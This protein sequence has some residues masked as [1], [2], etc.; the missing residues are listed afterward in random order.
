MPMK[1]L[2]CAAVIALLA[3]G[4]GGAGG[5]RRMMISTSM[6]A[7]SDFVVEEP[8]KCATGVEALNCAAPFKLPPNGHVTDFSTREW[9]SSS[10]K[11]CNE[12]GMHGSIFS[13]KGNGANDSNAISVNTMDASLRLAL[14]VSSGSYGG[15]GIAF[16]AGCLDA[17]AFSGLQFSIAVA[18]GSLSGCAY[19]IQLQTFEQR[20][21]SQN[22][23]GGCDINTTS[24]YSFP[25]VRNNL[26]A[27]STDPTMPTLVSLPFSMFSASTMPAPAQIVGL[28]WQVNS[29]S[30]QCTV[31]LRLDDV[32][33]IPAAASPEPSDTDG[34][35]AD[36]DTSD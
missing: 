25:Y 3:A 2:V 18:S 6:D 12:G 4:C 29:T 27:A 21:T 10:G 17:S 28:Q 13:F 5:V 1:S 19:Q 20:P 14:T 34:G 15:G 11:W 33:F 30:G 24:C 26:P 7:A 22:P 31:E 36:A 16:E 32:G 9:S 23:P 8:F 35:T